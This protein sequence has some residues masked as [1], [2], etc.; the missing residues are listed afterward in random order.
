MDRELLERELRELPLYACEFIR[1]AE[2]TFSGRVRHICR[3][4]C[5]MYGHSWSCPPAVGTLEECRARATAF[6]EG[7]LIATAIEVD[8]AADMR[9]SL[10]ARAPHEAITRR[11]LELV[12]RQAKEALALSGEACARCGR[13][14]W[15]DVPCRRPEEM[16][17]CLE[18]YGILV[19]ELAERHGI[20]LDAGGN[21]VT[22]FSLILYR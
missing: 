13:C 22:W 6:E 20:E 19:T 8:D 11:V 15:P 18:G 5:A 10:A 9:A 21:A 14:A 16:L 7:L 3:T 2:L 4:Q 12:R 1:T 17:P